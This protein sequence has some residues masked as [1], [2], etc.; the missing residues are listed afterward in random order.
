V[1]LKRLEVAGEYKSIRGT[2]DKPFI[3]EFKSPGSHDSPLCL[4]G[5][6]GSGKSNFI[7]LI[8]DIFGF[9]DRYSNPQYKIKA[10]FP[11]EFTIE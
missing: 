6:N 5:L 2:T 9:V 11:Y 8:A 7:E 1:K 3:Y 4:V 10:D